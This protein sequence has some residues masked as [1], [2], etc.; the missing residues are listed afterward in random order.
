MNSRF[1]GRPR[2]PQ[3]RFALVDQT[4]PPPQSPFRGQRARVESVGSAEPAACIVL[5]RR[6]G[7][8]AH[9]FR[10]CAFTCAGG[11]VLA[12][13]LIVALILRLQTGP[14]AL[15][16]LADRITEELN[17]R[18]GSGYQFHLGR[19]E[20]AQDQSSPVVA[21]E[22]LTV[23]SASGLTV[24]VAPRARL[25]IDPWGLFLG[26][27]RPSGLQLSDLDLRL[28]I[29]PDGAVAIAAGSEPVILNRSAPQLPPASPEPLA[30]PEPA[31]TPASSADINRK[32]LE[33]MSAIVAGIL[34]LSTGEQSPL[35]PL[36]TVSITRGRLRF[37][38][39]L[40]DQTTT[41]EDLQ[42]ELRR[43]DSVAELNFSVSGP[44]GGWTA[45]ARADGRDGNGRKLDLEVRDLA[46]D[47]IALLAGLRDP[48][49]DID[50]PLSLRL[51]LS[52]GAD[53]TLSAVEGRFTTGAGYFFIR[54][55]D[56][57]PVY[58]NRAQLGFSW[59]PASRSFTFAP[60]EVV[61]GSTRIAF[62]GR[63]SP[64]VEPAQPWSVE[65][66]TEPGTRFGADRPGEVVVSIDHAT[67]SGHVSR[68]DMR[69]SVERFEATGPDINIAAS[70][71][72][73]LES[74]GPHLRTA[75]TASRMPV[76]ALLRVWPSKAAAPVRSYLMQNLLGGTIEGS[77][78]TD[79]SGAMLKQMRAQHAPPD[80]SSHMDFTITNGQLQFLPG[81]PPLGGIEATGH[82]TGRTANISLSHG[83]IEG[84]NGHRL[85]ASD[86]IFV[87]PNNAF[88][89]APASINVR[90]NGTLEA[91]ADFL[92][93]DAMKPFG[94]FV[95]DTSMF[96]GQVDGRLNVD[97]KLENDPPPED[98]R[99]SVNATVAQLSI[100][101]VIG[102]ERLDQGQL[103][104]VVTPDGL[105]AT[106]QGRLFGNQAG[107]E[108]EKAPTS[109]AKATLSVNL[110]DAAR[111]K[112]GFLQGP[113]VTGPIGARFTSVFASSEPQPA[114]VELDLTK[115]EIQNLIPGLVKPA[116][117]SARASFVISPEAGGISVESFAF[118]SAVGAQARG[119]MEF[120]KTDTI[121]SA[122]FTQ[123]RLSPGDDMKVD[124]DMTKDAL[125][126]TVRGS[127]IDSRPFIKSVFG[128]ELPTGDQTGSRDIDLDLKS[129][130]VTGNNRQALTNV[131][132]RVSRRSGNLR[133]L[134]L[135]AKSG[136]SPL[137]AGLMRGQGGNPYVSLA[138]SD[139]GGLLSFLDIYR[140]MESG[141]LQLNAHVDDSG[142]EGS[143][144]INDFILRDEPA[145]RRIVTEGVAA[146]DERNALKIDTTAV[147]FA[148][149]SASFS[150]TPGKL[151]VS[152][153]VL[154]GPQIGLKLDGTID[155]QRDRTNL[156][157]TFVP[158]YGLNNL[159]SQIPLFGPI[160]GGGTNEGLF[161]VNFRITGPAS[162]P[163]LTI[164]PLSAIAP[165]MFRK[166]FGV[167][168]T[169][170]PPGDIPQTAA[171][172]QL[173]PR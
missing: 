162:A 149:L 61:Y 114:K 98:I 34:D 135:Q 74:D 142:I 30:S 50:M 79:F 104:V 54:D 163:V 100:E 91:L 51:N 156:T 134:Q 110:D 101:H 151:T 21:V 103:N 166:I 123:L 80:D 94:G 35:G 120:D 16:G 137:T 41:F 130:L 1:D 68:E 22:Q 131:E 3:A 95:I 23:E 55:P 147:Q 5:R 167:T 117:K 125:Q 31:A 57:E 44:T 127:S 59:D 118:D 159:F 169:M 66:R 7:P 128:S 43:Q 28:L 115:T 150:R 70:G 87:I 132:L 39:R 86:G 154:Y 164:N 56:A 89:P 64:P 102:K 9:V 19:I 24:L 75:V 99:V 105:K 138:T 6:R 25:T 72:L 82:L 112:L 33:G 107:L 173:G 14:L 46:F 37:E 73:T 32:E 157:G 26:R 96:R 172:L 92:G 85:V 152:D 62:S 108:I 139:A 29:E 49:V 148:R 63:L 17:A 109:D 45:Q 53:S 111:A 42:I 93:R 133:N 116:G 90:V 4:Q 27:V 77:L 141:K 10:L 12:L 8:V 40:E 160:L 52:L 76:R 158:A 83:F 161:A 60:S 153:G 81:M 165:G 136:R 145:F 58:V 2:G 38:D 113:S 146:R 84:N 88:K 129:P 69:L 65:L 78:A 122:R 140:R 48:P 124:A 67:L 155:Y 121:K 18:I 119:S 144:L 143:F 47:E 20:L 170:M 106:G 168:D 71:D 13:S 11:I 97:L 126:L 15:D 36:R 171:P